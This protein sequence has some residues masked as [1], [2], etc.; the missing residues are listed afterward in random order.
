MQ[1]HSKKENV[2]SLIILDIK[3]LVLRNRINIGFIFQY[4]LIYSVT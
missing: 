2:K 1:S 4:F 3:Y